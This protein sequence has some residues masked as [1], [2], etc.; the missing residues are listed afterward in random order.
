MSPGIT[1]DS[2][3][4]LALVVFNSSGVE[5]LSWA[6]VEQ[7]QVSKYKYESY[8]NNWDIIFCSVKFVKLRCLSLIFLPIRI[9]LYKDLK[10]FIFKTLCSE[11]KHLRSLYKNLSKDSTG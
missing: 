1:D 6:E 11:A 8:H 4:T 10:C 9:I 3:E 7:C 2:F 5:G